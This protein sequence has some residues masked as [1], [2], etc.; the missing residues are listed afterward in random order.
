[1]SQ[2]VMEQ[3]LRATGRPL[4]WWRIYWKGDGIPRTAGG[5]PYEPLDWKGS[6][7]A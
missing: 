5:H 7:N 3:E 2:A 6:I 4:P 1:M